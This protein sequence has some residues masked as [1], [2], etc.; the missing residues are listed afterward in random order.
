MAVQGFSTALISALKPQSKPYDL[1]DKAVRGLLLRVW[2][3][4]SKSWLLRYK[5]NGGSTPISLGQFPDIGLAKAREMAVEN[6]K[7]LKRGIDPRQAA[8]DNSSPKTPKQ[9][10]KPAQPDA[11]RIPAD[12]ASDL[13]SKSKQ[14][15]KPGPDDKTS[16]HYLAY[17]YVEH[18]VKVFR[19]KSV[20]EVV[21]I[22]KK[23]VLSIWKTRD[24]R[25]IS[26]AEI[27]GLLN[28]IV[29]REVSQK[30]VFR[31]RACGICSRPEAGM[32]VE[33]T[34][35][36]SYGSAASHAAASCAD[37]D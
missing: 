9:L 20:R 5:W 17:E 28:G 22:L 10:T 1:S 34:K 12:A 37:I 15:E 11:V 36:H 19:K 21:R 13:A 30:S 23:D 8:R 29:K 25:T 2:T 32:H 3:N 24:A 35:T 33:A 31:R 7:W 18:Y 4:G 16:V 14:I 6:R 26:S 27:I